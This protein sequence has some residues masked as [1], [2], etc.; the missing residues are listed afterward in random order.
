LP[1]LSILG[2]R[3]DSVTFDQAVALIES[4]IADGRPHQI[5]TVNPEFI[6]TAQRDAAFRAVINGCALALPDGIGVWWASRRL[7]R[8]LPERVPG[9]DLVLR[10]AQRSAARG[11]RLYLL[12]AMPGVAERAAARLQARYPGVVIAG[13]FAGF[14][15]REDEADLVARIRASRPDILFVAFGAPAQD[16]W[17]ARNRE[18]LGVPV[19]IGV[20]GA[21]DYIAGVRPLAPRWLRRLGL[22]WLHRLITQPWRWRRMLALP[23]FVWHVLR[24]SPQSAA[25]AAPP[26]D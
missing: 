5:T 19:A 12:G 15:R 18:A 13:T 26:G 1:A 11:Y 9:V 21:F 8:P 14:P 4:F 3:V 16:H 24:Q 10:L 25:V 22:E 2:V 17:I 7:G 20:G 6:M 23:R